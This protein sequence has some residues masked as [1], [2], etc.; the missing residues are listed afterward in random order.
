MFDVLVI[1]GG[2]A[3]VSAAIQAGREGASVVL[4][5]ATARLGGTTVNSSIAR[6]G[7]FHAWKRQICGGIGWELVLKTLDEARMPMPD[8]KMDAERWWK[9]Q[10]PID[11]YVYSAI[12]ADEV[13]KAGVDLRLRT[14]LGAL[15][16]L[17]AGGWKATLCDN[18]GLSCVEAAK[19]I[20]CSGDAV[21]ARMAGANI[22]KPEVCQ[23]AT[24]VFRM[25]GYDDRVLDRDALDAAF[26]K[27]VESGELKAEDA[28]WRIDQPQVHELLWKHG[29]NGTHVAATS[30]CATAR[31][32]TA[33]E[34][35]GL[36]AFRRMVRWLKRQ[37]GLENM[38][39]VSL[40]PEIGIR[41]SVVVEGLATVTR[42]DYVAGV[43]VPEAICYSFYPI[44]AHGIRSTDW[45][46][47]NLKEG[48]VATIP[49]GSIVAR[50]V[51]DFLMAGRIIS[52]DRLSN[53][54]LRTQPTCM[55]TGQAAGAL[56]VLSVRQGVAAG[57]VPYADLRAMLEKHG[58]ILPPEA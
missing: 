36:A 35:E 10:I 50:G 29:G 58:A 5:E 32:R 15:E 55:A 4:V 14:M 49:R 30:D 42:E 7:M 39:V 23:P 34:L 31:G 2:T 40:C 41:E 53:S 47:E 44:D 33:L 37:P 26:V 24:Y 38:H 11:P 17:P 8:Y 13:V 25:D 57:D 1:G 52:S 20:D 6:P 3:G 9:L 46:T 48:I 22:I 27:A 28:C 18:D 12:C 21:A 51:P 45:I 43:V 16:R 19:V 54:A 56:A